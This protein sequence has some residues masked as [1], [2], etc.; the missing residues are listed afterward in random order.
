MLE[1]NII[2]HL[3]QFI[4]YPHI[5]IKSPYNFVSRFFNPYIK[6]EC[7]KFDAMLSKIIKRQEQDGARVNNE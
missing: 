4:T 2:I 3:S 6:C 1:I 5:K 7:V